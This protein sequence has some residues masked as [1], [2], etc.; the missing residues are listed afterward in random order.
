M[1]ECRTIPPKPRQKEKKGYDQRYSEVKCESSLLNAGV[2]S[3][4]EHLRTKDF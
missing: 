2:N 1:A 3:Q 4:S